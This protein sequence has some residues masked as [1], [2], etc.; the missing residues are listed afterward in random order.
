M[1]KYPPVVDSPEETER[2]RETEREQAFLNLTYEISRMS[3]NVFFK[4]KTMCVSVRRRIRVELSE[5]MT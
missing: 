5:N 2:E 4:N 1:M 3:R